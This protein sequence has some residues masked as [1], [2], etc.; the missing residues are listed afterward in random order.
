[1]KTRWCW[2]VAVV[3]TA[4]TGAGQDLVA[5]RA[6]LASVET[7]VRQMREQAAKSPQLAALR[8][9][10]VQTGQAYE[11]AVARLPEVKTVDT[12]LAVLQTRVAELMRARETT[13]AANR[14]KLATALQ[15]RESAAAA[16]SK[17][18]L[19]GEAG[20]A[21]LLRRQELRAKLAQAEQ[22]PGRAAVGTPE[23]GPGR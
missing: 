16:F 12:E 7:Q 17:A 9:T 15:A 22:T 2:L 20:A 18:S 23:L 13:I 14:D 11:E 6:E 1:M 4:Q 5:L 19:G 3:V 8:Q 10:M 21:L